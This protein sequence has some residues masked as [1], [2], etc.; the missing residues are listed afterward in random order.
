MSGL[1]AR[2]Q[3]PA[4]P[5]H[6]DRD[7]H[8]LGALPLPVWSSDLSGCVTYA[9]DAFLGL[10]GIDVLAPHEGWSRRVHPEDADYLDQL[11]EATLERRPFRGTTRVIRADGELRWVESWGAP[12][13]HRAILGVSVDVTERM[14]RER[15]LRLLDRQVRERLEVFGH[16]FRNSLAALRNALHL[17]EPDGQD[18]DAHEYHQVLMRQ[19]GNMARLLDELL[20]GQARRP[21]DD[22]ETPPGV[23]PGST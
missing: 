3:S 21:M 20:S 7:V 18:P 15:R 14:H 16:E 1:D 11:R 9:N 12:S 22:D 10:L 13:A 6:D 4:R 2:K 19:S 5:V 23:G 17:L 8:A